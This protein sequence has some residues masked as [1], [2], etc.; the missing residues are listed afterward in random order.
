MG[1]MNMYIYIWIY[2]YMDIWIYGYMDIYIYIHIHMYMH[3]Y[4]Y[5]Y[6]RGVY[7][8][9]DVDHLLIDIISVRL[10]IFWVFHDVF[11]DD[12]TSNHQTPIALEVS[13]T[14][15]ARSFR[16][17]SSR[18]VEDPAPQHIPMKDFANVQSLDSSNTPAGTNSV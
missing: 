2:G 12:S 14:C 1:T 6:S 15:D 18:F 4:L 13:P 11:F 17:I 7:L 9:Y 10:Q 3:V 5:I 16:S 8:C